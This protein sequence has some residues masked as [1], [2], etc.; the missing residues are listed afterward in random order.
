MPQKRKRGRPPAALPASVVEEYLSGVPA[1]ELARRY[2]VNRSTIARHLRKEGCTSRGRREAALQRHFNQALQ[3]EVNKLVQLLEELSP[4]KTWWP[5]GES[6]M[7]NPCTLLVELQKSRYEFLTGVQAEP[8]MVRRFETHA[9]SIAQMLAVGPLKGKSLEWLLDFIKWSNNND[10]WSGRDKK[11]YVRWPFLLYLLQSSAVQ[12]FE[13]WMA[14]HGP[15]WHTQAK[16]AAKAEQAQRKL[17]EFAIGDRLRFP[18]GTLG[19]VKS[20][21]RDFLVIERGTP[22]ELADPCGSLDRTR[23]YKLE[24]LAECRLKSKPR[25][26]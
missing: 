20:R 7:Y 17:R 12:Q 13:K 6:A 1:T 24:E 2:N 21:G 25:Q 23:R 15:G 3:S 8:A 26:S 14:K 10:F 5:H 11:H 9:K 19:V 4:D 16:Q 18:D 22:E